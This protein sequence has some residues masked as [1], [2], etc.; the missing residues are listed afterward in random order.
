MIIGVE[1]H[2]GC[3]S[4]VGDKT[5]VRVRSKIEEYIGHEYDWDHYGLSGHSLSG[6]DRGQIEVLGDGEQENEQD[7]IK[8]SRVSNVEGA[9]S[10]VEKYDANMN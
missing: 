3:V 4:S 6:K 5:W 10:L 8:V 9:E 2:V 1:A 7:L